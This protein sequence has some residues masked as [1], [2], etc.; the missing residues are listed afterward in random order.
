MSRFIFGVFSK[1]PK[2]YVR[3][4]PDRQPLSRSNNRPLT[5]LL[6]ATGAKLQARLGGNCQGLFY[7]VCLS[8]CYN[9]RMV[10]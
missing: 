4:G 10:F 3:M 1:Y 8:N 2:L 6:D 9:L 5:K 7:C